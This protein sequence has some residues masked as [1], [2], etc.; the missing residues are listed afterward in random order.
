MSDVQATAADAVTE[1]AAPVV[2]QAV[3]ASAADAAT[4][5]ASPVADQP[6]QA[7]AAVDAA[8]EPVAT[9]ADVAGVA[10]TV[11]AAEEVVS[12]VVA[13]AEAVDPKIGEL[14]S[15]LA[16]VKNELFAILTGI[17]T[18]AHNGEAHLVSLIERL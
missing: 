12:D 14:T 10:A 15:L 18:R 3:Q 17:R 6:E 11:D 1:V 7:S 8:A 9:D 13:A 5:S 16:T 2:D 4:E